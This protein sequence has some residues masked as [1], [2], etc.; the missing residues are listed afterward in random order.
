VKKI[1]ALLIL[2][3][4]LS[5]CGGG[6]GSGPILIVPTS[7]ETLE[8]VD[9]TDEQIETYKEALILESKQLNLI[10]GMVL[11]FDQ[12]ESAWLPFIARAKAFCDT[13]RTTGWDAAKSQYLDQ[14]LLEATNAMPSEMEGVEPKNVSIQEV[15]ETMAKPQF[16]AIAAEGSLCPELA[17]QGFVA[18]MN[19]E[20]KPTATSEPLLDGQYFG[21]GCAGAGQVLLALLSV[22]DDIENG[23][24][25]LDE[26][27]ERIRN[28]AA[29]LVYAEMSEP[30]PVLA[31]KIFGGI[32]PLLQL[33]LAFQNQDPE[34]FGAAVPFAVQEAINIM[35]ACGL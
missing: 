32:P 13:A 4:S 26:M 33:Q 18:D 24:G 10:D 9:Y 14:V 25:N 11:N 34:K 7:A 2:A 6:I 30:N 17:P 35:D 3:F 16:L 21:E 19:S 28:I 27:N 31:E 15:L 1:I 29:G 5:A 23:R 20:L 12:P 8:R 22:L